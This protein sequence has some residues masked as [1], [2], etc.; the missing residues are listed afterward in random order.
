MTPR[1]RAIQAAQMLG[2]DE[3][4]SERIPLMRERGAQE[5]TTQ[6][7]CMG[8]RGPAQLP[9]RPPEKGVTE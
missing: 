6:M 2:G 1:D 3:H 9:W 7:G 8:A 5:T 4:R